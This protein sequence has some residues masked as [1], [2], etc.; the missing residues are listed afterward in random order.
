M[1]PFMHAFYH[2]IW[3]VSECMDARFVR[4]SKVNETQMHGFLS[5]YIWPLE[6]THRP[7]VPTCIRID[8]QWLIPCV[9]ISAILHANLTHF[10]LQ[11]HPFCALK[12]VRLEND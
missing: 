3:F 9:S 6:R 8:N 11:S 2:A 5:E 7:C 10:T 4:P 1:M 12:W